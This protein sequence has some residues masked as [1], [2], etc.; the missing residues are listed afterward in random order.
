MP[1]APDTL[2]R[3]EAFHLLSNARRRYVVRS[4]SGREGPVELT[5]LAAELAARENG[6]DIEEIEA[7]ERKRVYVSLFQTHVPRLEEAGIVEYE[8]DGGTVRIAGGAE[9]LSRYLDPARDGA[10]WHRYYLGLSLLTALVVGFA[11]LDIPGFHLVSE[12]LVAGAV[13]VAFS[14][15][16]MVHRRA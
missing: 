9:E 10:A 13:L 4:L 15:V 3:D 11:L 16:A 1:P 2:S 7:Q 6:K 8:P 5:R 12:A 14:A